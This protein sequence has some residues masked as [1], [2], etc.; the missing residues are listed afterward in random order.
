MNFDDIYFKPI[1]SKN[2]IKFNKSLSLSPHLIN[3]IDECLKKC[4]KDMVFSKIPY[5]LNKSV[6]GN[7]NTKNNV[8]DSKLAALKLKA[9]NCLSYSYYLQDLLKKKG[10][11][12]YIIPSKPPTQYMKDGYSHISHVAVALPFN[13][14]YIILDPAIYVKI[15][16]ILYDY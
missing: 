13:N 15:P 4:F 2:E 7:N 6:I 12:S 16:V 11:K 1:F 3:D 9:G 8:P 10:Y 14:G 5:F